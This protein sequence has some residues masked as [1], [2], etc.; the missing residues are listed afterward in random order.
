MQILASRHLFAKFARQEQEPILGDR[1]NLHIAPPDNEASVFTLKRVG[2]VNTTPAEY[3]SYLA[4]VPAAP[5]GVAITGGN[6]QL[7]LT[8][9]PGSDGGD[10]ILNYLYST[11]DGATYTAFSPQTGPVTSLTI[12]GLTNGTTYAVK[13]KAVNSLGEGPA[14]VTA[15]GTPAAVPAAPTGLS[16]TSGYNYLTI[17][18]TA[19]NDGGSPLTNYKYSIDN[20]TSYTALS[21][22]DTTSPIT[23]TGLTN[24]TTYQVKLRAVNAVGDG[25]QS[26]ALSALVATVPSAPTSLSATAGSAQLTISF[27]PGANNGA[28]ITNYKYSI[29]NGATYTAFSP[30]DTTSPVTITG[31][32]NNT[33]YQV[34]L[35]AVN[36]IGDGAESSAVSG[37]PTGGTPSEPTALSAVGGN[38]AA[39]ILFTTPASNGGSAITNYEYSVDGGA[40]TAVSPAQTF[41]PVQITGLTNSTTYSVTLRAVNA[42]GSGTASSSVSV[43]PTTTALY[44]TNRL[45]RLE[46]GD[47]NSYSGSGTAWTNLDSSGSY[48]ATLLNAPIY[49]SATATKYFT[50]DGVN[51]MAQ[52]A[53]AAAINPTVGSA[54]TLQIW[55]RVDLTSAN[56][57]SGD[58]LI[59]KQYDSP[60]YDGYCLGL[61]ANGSMYLKMN[62]SGVD[63]TY[64]SPADVYA[65]ATWYLYTI[66]VC[67]GGGSGSPSYVYVNG[68][69]VA[70]GNNSDFG[71]PSNN[72]PLQFP[73]GLQNT[74]YN[75]CPADVGAFYVY[76]T[77]LSQEDIIR[78]FDATKSTY[79]L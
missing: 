18:F 52:I 77:A 74:I 50:F 47:S 29:D 14:S 53:A 64:G 22:A 58:G 60:S 4:T 59:S 1:V 27:T 6:Q 30:A 45:V 61:N 25:V 54:F 69:R 40:F 56:F 16:Y 42:N 20:G 3:E 66:V 76:N 51:Q 39:Y 62:G 5:S 67:F 38:G 24:G 37:T 13:L 72:A 34:K 10:P 19:G 11:D 7:V 43:T 31:L 73:R 33:T 26:T 28:A 36:A 63:G 17:S 46:A 70:T 44:G 65:T 8:L 68:R 12:T 48:S 32:T 41:S 79:G 21:P 23:I 49:Q 15:Y 71:I 2:E 9:T 35:R 57:S 78:N 55:A 75:F